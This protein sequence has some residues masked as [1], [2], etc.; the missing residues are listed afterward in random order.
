MNKSTNSS[1]ADAD[2]WDKI[3][4]TAKVI[5]NADCLLIGVGSG[6]SASCGLNYSDP[7][8]AQK[9]YP[10]YFAQGKKS[11]IE[12]MSDFWATSIN[13]KNATAFWG[14]W[15]KH[16]YHIRYECEALPPYQHLFNIAKDRK[17]FIC[18]TN[19]DCQL[20]KAG[21]D[22][23]S[24]FAPQGNYAFFQCEKPCSQDIYDNEKMIK[25]MLENMVSPF[26]IR[27]EDIPH[28]PKCGKHLMPNL[29]CDHRFVEQ[30]HII[31]QTPYVNYVTKVCE[32]KLVL[33]ELGVG[34]NTPVIIRYPFEAITL[35]YPFATLIRVNL[36]DTDVSE[37]IVNK[38]VCIQEDAGK[39]LSD[40]CNLLK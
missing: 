15:A 32:K 27:K 18:T 25:T 22:N 40:L 31:N 29:R 2:Y 35:K 20:Y 12:I 9:W 8:L 28:C 34:Y 6:M 39:V 24:V 37:S 17:Y 21:F 33:L 16:I 14:F 5:L 38:S 13:D 23:S 1:F 4:K 3:H 10:E 11:I 30:P 26:D 36:S 19:V 7:A